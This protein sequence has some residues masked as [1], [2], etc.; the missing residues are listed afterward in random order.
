MHPNP[1]IRRAPQRRIRR[2]PS[3]AQLRSHHA[4]ASCSA[5]WKLISSPHVHNAWAAY[6]QRHP[7]HTKRGHPYHWTA[8]QAFLHVN[9][10]RAR[11]GVTLAQWPP[12][13]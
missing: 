11:T 6:S 8:Y 10:H 12:D 13:D 9:L 5:F 1:K 2:T 7:Q 3:D 4:F